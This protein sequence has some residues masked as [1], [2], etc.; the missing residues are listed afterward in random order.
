MQIHR[1]RR[2]ARRS[3]RSSFDGLSTGSHSSD[4]TL[5]KFQGCSHFFVTRVI[6]YGSH[7]SRGFR[8]LG[9]LLFCSFLDSTDT[10][11]IRN[12]ELEDAG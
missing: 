8:S 1:P 2:A 7:D 9:L 10:T 4:A 5:L 12:I 6:I 3:R 11:H